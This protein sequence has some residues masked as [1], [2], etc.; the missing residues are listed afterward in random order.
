MHFLRVSRAYYLHLVLL[1]L[2]QEFKFLFQEFNSC[3]KN[4]I[5]HET[6]DSSSAISP[7]VMSRI[8]ID[9]RGFLLKRFG[10]ALRD[11]RIAACM[12]HTL[13]KITNKDAC[14]GEKRQRLFPTANRRCHRR[15]L[16]RATTLAYFLFKAPLCDDR[17]DDTV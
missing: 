2:F 16:A 7:N 14:M 8:Q 3:S 12:E 6:K 9:A 13:H 11:M 17:R 10:I 1:L 15:F 4:L 5:P